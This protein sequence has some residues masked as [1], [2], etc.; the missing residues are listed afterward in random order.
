MTKSYSGNRNWGSLSL[1]SDTVISTVVSASWKCDDGRVYLSCFYT[2]QN[3]GKNKVLGQRD[4][5]AQTS[6]KVFHA[7]TAWGLVEGMESIT[8]GNN[9]CIRNVQDQEGMGILY[10]SSVSVPSSSWKYIYVFVLKPVKPS[11]FVATK[12]VRQIFIPVSPT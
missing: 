5:C 10:L 4:N 9:G 7:I 12:F 11:L 6:L 3:V 2:S 1:S 8:H